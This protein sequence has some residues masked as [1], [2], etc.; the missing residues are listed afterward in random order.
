[1]VIAPTPPISPTAAAGGFVQVGDTLNRDKSASATDP[2][3]ASGTTQA[4][5]PFDTWATWAEKQGNSQQIFVSR[6][7]GDAWEPVG[8]SL[9]IH[10][11]VVGEKP[12][13]DFAGAD[14]TVPWVA[15]S[16]PSPGFGNNK[17][18]FVS[19][20]N[21]ASGLWV[22]AGQD[23]GGNEPSLNVHTQKP[24]T[25]PILTGGSLDPSQPP[26]PWVCWQEDSAN[27]N[28]IQVYVARG[29]RDES[30]LGGFRWVTVGPNRGG[31]E[32]DPEPSLNLD[33][34]QGDGLHCGITFAGENNT[35]PWVTW[36][37]ISGTK[38]S[39]VFAARGV[40]DANAPGGLRWEFVPGCTDISQEAQC[41]LNLNPTRSATE[42]FITSGSV[43]PGQPAVPWVV[44]S[45]IGPSG[46]YQIYANRLDPTTRDRFL[47]VGGSLNVDQNSN[48]Q[49]P[50]ITFVGNVPYVAW[51]EEVG[52]V[53]RIFVRH[54]A[55]DPQT[56]TWTLDTPPDGLAVDK[57]VSA[58]KPIIHPK[59]SGVV[60][61][62]RQGDPEQGEVSQI[63]V[64][65][66]AG[67]TA[68]P[69]SNSC[70]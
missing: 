70:Q 29:E 63:I 25:N 55:S 65:A 53:K 14:R 40:V 38:P 4:G 37:E 48:A 56:G 58:F 18:I 31:T 51:E 2:N 36:A 46:K 68:T 50:S 8:A 17:Q 66:G 26:V 45:E 69:E 41:I 1:V 22:P 33:P 12:S 28:V 35:V 64:C 5:N 3:I 27:H 11:N 10:T 61:I 52:A 23:R 42:P 7:N 9:N 60:V 67:G 19:R 32:Q 16:E 6:L 30:S 21:T 13:I 39:R 49:A 62:Y 24:A 43:V 59:G 54:L 44:W 47:N 15:W 34:I 20:F 57:G